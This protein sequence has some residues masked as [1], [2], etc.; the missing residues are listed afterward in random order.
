MEYGKRKSGLL[1]PKHM[2]PVD[3][4]KLGGRFKGEIFRKGKLIDEFDVK[5][6]VVNQGLNDV[7]N[8]YLNGGGQITS[9]FMGLFQGNYTPVATDTASSIAG[10]STECSSYS[11][12]TRPQW[13]PAAPSGQS[14]S[15]SA[16]RATYTFTG[17]VTIYGAFLISSNVI[18]GTAGTLF[19]AAQF[20]SSKAVS[21]SDQLLLTYQLNALPT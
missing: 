5:N 7:L 12:S 10:N 21:N 16:N 8:T 20:G 3:G 2:I 15:N 4:L 18:G 19:A 13:S 1:V 17:S 9:W 11:S 14:I 6:L